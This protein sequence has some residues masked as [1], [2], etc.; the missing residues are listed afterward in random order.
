VAEVAK[1]YGVTV[2]VG[3]EQ[4]GESP[5]TPSDAPVV[6]A[7]GAQISR[8]YGVAPRP[9]GIGGGTV[10]AGLRRLGLSAVVW[11]RTTESA[12]APNEYCLLESLLGDTKV[13]AGVMAG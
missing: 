5:A 11:H 4:A 3:E 7:L 2:D 1:K 12:H 10:A 9:V 6:L 8:V 13:I